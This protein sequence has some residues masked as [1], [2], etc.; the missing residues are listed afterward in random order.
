[1]RIDVTSTNRKTELVPNTTEQTGAFR[2]YHVRYW[3]RVI[4][5]RCGALGYTGH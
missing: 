2:Q 5:L 4:P 1:M 3:H